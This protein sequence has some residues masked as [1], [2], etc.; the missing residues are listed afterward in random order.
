MKDRLLPYKIKCLNPDCLDKDKVIEEYI[1]ESNI[2]A[3]KMPLCSTCGKPLEFSIE[4]TK[5]STGIS[6]AFNTF[7]SLPN[8]DKKKILMN[9][10]QEHHKKHIQEKK[11]DMDKNYKP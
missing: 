7:N 5:E 11:I 1:W 8:S 6:V 3:N 2:E 4:E 9:R 10:S